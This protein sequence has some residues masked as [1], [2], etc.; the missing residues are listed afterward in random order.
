RAADRTAHLDLF[1]LRRFTPGAVTPGFS[2]PNIHDGEALRSAVQG[3]LGAVATKARDVIVVLPDAAIRV[4][5]L[6]FETLPAKA[7]DI[8]PV[9]RF[10][11][12]KSLPFDVDQAAVSYH[13]RRQSGTVHVVAAV[14]PKSVVNEYEAAFR[15][16]GYLPGVVIPSS[17]AA[18]GLVEANVPTLLL[19]VD[20]MNITIVAARNQ[21]LC[22]IRTLEN[23]HGSEVSPA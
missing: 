22:L 6:D 18:L 15:D 19:K 20:P 4:L 12:K 3:A 11:L 5:L 13:I 16:A 21:E 1:T 9:I 10:R 7:H 2:A 14:S 8:D 17:L 23:P